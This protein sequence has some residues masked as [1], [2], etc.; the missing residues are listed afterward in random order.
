MKAGRI[1]IVAL[2][3]FILG[4]PS[5]GLSEPIPDQVR[6][7]VAYI[8]KPGKEANKN[9]P[10]GTGFFVGYR[11]AEIPDKI[12]SF[13]VTARHVLFDDKGKLHRHLLLRLNDK[14]TGRARDFDILRMNAWFQ[15]EKD[16][17]AVDI[18]VQPLL[19]READ[20][21]YISSSDF[22]TEELLSKQKI[23]IGDELFYT[24]LLS[25]HSGREKIAPIV[26]F[27]RLA[28][29]TSEKTVDNKYYHFI[30]SGNIPG[31]SGSPV[32]LWATATRVPG[33]IVVGSRI[34]GLYG[35]VSGVLEYEKTLKATVP[36]ETE[37]R[38]ILLDARSGGITAVVP[39]R[40]LR[41]ILTG[42]RIKKAI[43]I[44]HK[45]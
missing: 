12:Y 30:D 42:S 31:H 16:G 22:V 28:L 35:I 15:H 37:R 39:V 43:G 3:T 4:F 20:F 18:A 13:L 32:F 10:V 45:E 26:R 34:F 36:R 44:I 38:V 25:Y 40:Y 21:L 11:Y 7:C 17:Q 5:L 19:P 6:K 9:T 33:Q 27:G 14:N 41:E 1:I 24:G 23:G 8:V 2:F 29:T